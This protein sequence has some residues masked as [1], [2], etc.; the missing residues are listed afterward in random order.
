VSARRAL[1][2]AHVAVQRAYRAVRRVDLY[3]ES[4]VAMRVDALLAETIRA[5]DH[6]RRAARAVGRAVADRDARSAERSAGEVD[7]SAERARSTAATA[8]SVS[9]R[10]GGG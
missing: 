4:D 7:R 3:P 2:K 5:R 6:A 8:D 9:R 10:A 1:E